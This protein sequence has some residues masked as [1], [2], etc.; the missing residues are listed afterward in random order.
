[1]DLAGDDGVGD[2]AATSLTVLARVDDLDLEI[3]MFVEDL[4]Y[5]TI[6]ATFLGLNLGGGCESFI[7]ESFVAEVGWSRY[8]VCLI[9]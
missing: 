8:E 7:F 5:P 3:G 4:L 6:V 1:M 9:G 2:V